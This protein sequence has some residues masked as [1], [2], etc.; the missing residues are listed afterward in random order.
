VMCLKA[1]FVLIQLSQKQQAK[2]RKRGGGAASRPE[3]EDRR[4]R[5]GE[6]R[7]DPRS[8]PVLSHTFDC[9]V[10]HD[11]TLAHRT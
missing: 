10:G 3:T 11:L 2:A 4:R 9:E 8:N 7:T 5:I 6:W 1:A